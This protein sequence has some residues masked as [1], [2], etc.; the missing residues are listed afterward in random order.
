M[1]TRADKTPWRSPVASTSPRLDRIESRCA[2]LRPVENEAHAETPRVATSARVDPPRL[3]ASPNGCPCRNRA[4]GTRAGADGP[5]R[6][7][8]PMP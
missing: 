5:G 8:C 1:S 3:P 7:G 4:E 2:R 6:R